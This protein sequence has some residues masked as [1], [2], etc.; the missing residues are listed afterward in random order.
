MDH[1]GTF[2]VTNFGAHLALYLVFLHIVNLP[3]M[4][5]QLIAAFQ[6]G[7][8][9]I[10]I[11][12]LNLPVHPN[13]MDLQFVVSI[14]HFVTNRAPIPDMSCMYVA[15]QLDDID[16]TQPAYLADMGMHNVLFIHMVHYRSKIVELL[17]A[18]HAR[19]HTVVQ[20]ERK[21]TLADCVIVFFAMISYNM[22]DE[23]RETA[24]VC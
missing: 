17:V 1:H 11:V 19:H 2:S 4:H 21:E 18:N 9:Q 12:A 10:A 7:T 3:H 6:T 22:S 5:F 15:I 23:I 24:N 8:A 16:E 13:L 14:E 20:D